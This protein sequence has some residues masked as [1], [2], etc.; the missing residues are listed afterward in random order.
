MFAFQIL[1]HHVGVAA[2]SLQSLAQPRLQPAQRALALRSLVRYPPASAQVAA[3]RVLRATHLARDRFD[4]QPRGPQPH[5]L[6]R[7][8]RR[9]HHLPPCRLDDG[10]RLHDSNHGKWPSRFGGSIP[11]VAYGVNL[12]CRLTA[13]TPLPEDIRSALERMRQKSLSAPTGDQ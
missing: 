3:Y 4:P 1:A 11:G 10:E 13:A 7:I 2:M 8:L 6:R 12:P 5:H 9:L